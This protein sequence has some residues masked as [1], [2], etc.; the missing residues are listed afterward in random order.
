M[1]GVPVLAP[2]H[3]PKRYNPEHQMQMPY[4]MDFVV[5]ATTLSATNL[6]N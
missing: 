2:T 5:A 4:H 3:V 6:K 1:V